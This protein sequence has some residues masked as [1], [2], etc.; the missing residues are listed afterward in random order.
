[1]STPKPSVRLDDADVDPPRRTRVGRRPHARAH[2]RPPL[3]VRPRRG[4]PAL[5]RPRPAHHHA[6]HLRDGHRRRPAGRSSS[7][8]STACTTWRAS[9]SPCPPTAIPS[10]SST[11]RVEAIKVHHEE[12]LELLRNGVDRARPA[13]DGAGALA[14]TSSRPAPRVRWPTSET[15]AHLEHLRLAG[16]AKVT[17]GRR[18][19]GVRRRLTL[20]RR[21]PLRFDRLLL[22]RSACSARCGASAEPDA[23]CSAHRA[24]HGPALGEV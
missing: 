16:H 15:Y 9:P 14:P 21:S 20:R 23:P 11:S 13:G 1:M 22:A 2:A 5:G 10:P 17:L 24:E 6:P 12:R 7:P 19:V 3:P 8:R 18:P 4:H